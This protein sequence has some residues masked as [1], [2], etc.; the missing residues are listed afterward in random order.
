MSSLNKHNLQIESPFFI[1]SSFRNLVSIRDDDDERK[2]RSPLQWRGKFYRD[3]GIMKVG[4]NAFPRHM[5]IPRQEGEEG[6][7][8]GSCLRND[9]LPLIVLWLH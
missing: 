8:D 6:S 4:S 5:V 7:S 1:P 3:I 9:R 2:M